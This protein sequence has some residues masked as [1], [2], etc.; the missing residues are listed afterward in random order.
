MALVS[1]KLRITV[2][3]DYTFFNDQEHGAG[4]FEVISIGTARDGSQII[5]FETP[6][7]ST[8]PGVYA[9][10]TASRFFNKL[11]T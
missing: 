10:S 9:I 7:G 4:E 8:T 3:V 11:K 2:V 5:T 1:D 6:E